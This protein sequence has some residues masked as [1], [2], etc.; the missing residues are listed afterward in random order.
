M[1]L[2]SIDIS[3]DDKISELKLANCVDSAAKELEVRVPA[4]LDEAAA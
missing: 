4:A 2:A 1:L 3:E